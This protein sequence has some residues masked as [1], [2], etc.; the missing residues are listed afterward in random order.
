[1][2]IFTRP[3]SL[4]YNVLAAA[5]GM[6]RV[7]RA[8]RSLE[9]VAHADGPAKTAALVPGHGRRHI[10][11]RKKRGADVGNTKRGK[12]TKIL[13]MVDGRGTPISAMTTT[14]RHAEVHCIETLVE[15]QVAGKRPKRLLYDKAADADWLRDSLANRG[16][17]LICPHRKNRRKP[18]RQDGRS[19]RRYRHRWIIERTISWL[20]NSRRLLVRHEYYSH[21]FDGFV[22]LAC[23]MLTLKWF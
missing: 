18:S 15:I 9:T 1:L 3:I 5:E 2:E 7:R 20:Q 14:A 8:A 11:A 19:L 12:G 22:T 23:L 17:E 21:L 13:L 16:I 10:F 4:S 6:D